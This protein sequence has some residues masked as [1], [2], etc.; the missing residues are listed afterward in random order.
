[1]ARWGVFWFGVL[2]SV[3]GMLT[4][5]VLVGCFILPVGLVLMLLGLIQS[6]PPIIVQVVNN[7]APPML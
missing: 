2:T 3:I 4:I 7:E 6:A 5:P 1:M